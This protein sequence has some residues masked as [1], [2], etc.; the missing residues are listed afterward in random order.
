MT[1]NAYL[2]KETKLLSALFIVASNETNWPAKEMEFEERTL[3]LR[4]LI[5][6]AKY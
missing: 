1:A 2:T 6:I 5:I 3:C 4:F